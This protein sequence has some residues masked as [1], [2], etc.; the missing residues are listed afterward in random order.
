MER[1]I[2]GGRL[3][4][5]ASQREPPFWTANWALNQLYLSSY[6][7]SR[8]FASAYADAITRFDARYF[9]GYT[10]AL[11]A[12]AQFVLESGRTDLRPKVV[13]TNAEP[14]YAH[15]RAL[16]ARAFQCPVV[17]TYGMTEMG[18]MAVSCREGYLHT[19]PDLG[20]LELVGSDD[21]PVP[22]GH[23][24]QVVT[25]SLI[26]REQMLIRYR[27]GDTAVGLPEGFEC[28]C[29]N[30][31]PALARIEGRSD[32]LLYTRDGRRI[33]RLDPMFKGDL[34]IREAQIIQ[35][36]WGRFVIRYVPGDGCRPAHE[37]R[38]ASALK[39][40]VGECEVL[41]EAVDMIERTRG[42][43]VRAVVCNLRPHATPC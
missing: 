30:A 38:M 15:Q 24:G 13:I 29:G 40:R 3:V 42:G 2:L 43:K 31:A 25:T 6:H 32:D 35:E 14:L 5:P 36:D 33:G 12:L 18:V 19:W 37:A 16:I 41:F 34:P 20:Y 26:N 11:C 7:L 17:E 4:A 8:Q 10:S 39:A 28:P 1:S 23:V 27:T 22:P 9:L 21:R